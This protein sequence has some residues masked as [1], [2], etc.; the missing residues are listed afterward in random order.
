M[1]NG[2][3]GTV[4]FE[5]R[6]QSD[7][8]FACVDISVIRDTSLSPCD[9]AVFAVICSYVNIQS[10]H[11]ILKVQTIAD[12]AGCGIRTAQKSLQALVNRGVIERISR[13]ENGKQKASTYRIIG[14][15]AKCY[16]SAP[17]ERIDE[18]ENRGANSA[19][20]VKN[21]TPMGANSA[22]QLLEPR[23]Y[24]NQEPKTP[25]TPQGGGENDGPFELE[26]QKQETPA[27]R[28]RHWQGRIIDAYHRILPELPRADKLTESRVRAIRKCV[29]E[30][31][32]RKELEWWSRYFERVRE[33]PFL[34]GDNPEVWKAWFDW[35]L[36]NEPMQKVL[37]GVYSRR[38]SNNGRTTAGEIAQEKYTRDGGEIDARAML[39]DLAATGH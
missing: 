26:V 32:A 5:A 24:E 31:P 19:G 10:R 38:G 11:W 22:G 8:W 36:R 3:E 35:L 9:K 30:D 33:F 28:E 34:L 2:S 7:F 23:P 1:Q 6:E 14:H 20:Y 21:C 16:E 29:K 13:F 18:T 12:A 15:R 17:E 37:E 39:R 4:E 25:P 27:D